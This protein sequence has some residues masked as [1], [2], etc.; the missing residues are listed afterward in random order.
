MNRQFPAELAPID[1]IA[2][3]TGHPVYP[4][5]LMTTAQVEAILGNPIY[6]VIEV[7]MD[8][9]AYEEGHLP[10]AILWN[11][12]KQLRNTETHEILTPSEF[13]ELLGHS[14]ITPLTRIVLYGDNNN[15]FACWAYWLLHMIGHKHVWLMDGG[16]R[17]WFS[18]SRPVTQTVEEPMPASYPL[19][20]YDL[21]DK[22]STEQVF[23]S[24][25]S[26]KTHRLIDVRSSAEFE[27]KLRGPA[28]LE[29]RCAT[30]GR[31]PTSINIP[32]NLN[33]NPDGTF[34]NPE[35][36]L[37][38]YESFDVLPDNTIITYCAIGERASLSWFVLKM[39]LGYEVVMNYDRS[40]AEWSRLANAPII[41]AEA[42]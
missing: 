26:P 39:L 41:T 20:A 23:E 27:G 29:A 6:R 15:W 38:L 19:R 4:R 7:D 33:C 5:Q 28:G 37:S 11:W 32:W 2:A 8:P 30:A 40:M 34:K 42:A 9:E 3:P 22:A 1:D 10:G 12:E 36:L 21:E 14:G 24:F 31:I 18:Q 13:A 16:S 25:F 35:E 17:A